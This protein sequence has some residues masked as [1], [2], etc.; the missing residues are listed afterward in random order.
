MAQEQMQEAGLDKSLEILGLG[1][2]TPDTETLTSEKKTEEKVEEPVETPQAAEEPAE[3]QE[4]VP[5]EEQKRRTWQSERD[6]AVA[7]K[8]RLEEQVRLLQQ[9][10]AQT[11]AMMNE[12]SRNIAQPQPIKEEMPE[13]DYVDD[14]GYFDPQKHAAWLKKREAF[15][16]SRITEKSVRE[17]QKLQEQQKYEQQAYELCKKRP[18]FLNPLTGKPD[19]AKIE[20][21]VREKTG[22][23]TL[24]QVLGVEERSP[25][26]SFEAIAERASKPSSVVSSQET[27]KEREPVPEELKD[28]ASLFPDA[29]GDLPPGFAGFNK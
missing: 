10:N 16:E 5:E 17:F 15:L 24:S 4:E 9:Q 27:E 22:G 19:Y 20:Q 25:D 14:S 1:G 29:P 18:E 3:K 8:Q 7:E 23:M 21:A 12:F 6:K 26:K 11:V 13:P 2:D 28:I